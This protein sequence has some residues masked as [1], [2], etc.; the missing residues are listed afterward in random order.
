MRRLLKRRARVWA[1]RGWQLIS[2]REWVMMDR[3]ENSIV[4][5]SF[6]PLLVEDVKPLAVCVCVFQ[7]LTT[8]GKLELPLTLDTKY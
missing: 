7:I 3:W 1:R 8:C 6:S 2:I 5:H 4:L